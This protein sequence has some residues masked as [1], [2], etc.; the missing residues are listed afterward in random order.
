MAGQNIN[1]KYLICQIPIKILK[2]YA[3][4]NSSLQNLNIFSSKG[5][6]K[7]SQKWIMYVANTAILEFQFFS[8]RCHFRLWVFASTG[9]YF[10]CWH[11]RVPIMQS[12]W[13]QDLQK[14]CSIT[15]RF[16]LCC[17]HKAYVCILQIDSFEKK[18]VDLVLYIIRS[19]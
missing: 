17:G 12:T 11:W 14:P 9:E 7:T 2:Q 3:I 6:Q 18:N 8:E 10:Y 19:D 15:L 16:V 4:P 1:K 5:Y 13:C